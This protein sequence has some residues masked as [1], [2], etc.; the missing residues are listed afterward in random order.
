MV[1]RP[2][3]GETPAEQLA[4]YLRFTDDRRNAHK[5]TKASD[6]ALRRLAKHLVPR[7]SRSR[8]RFLV[9]DLVR[10][11]ARA[12][13]R[14]IAAGH[15]AS[16]KDLLL[17][18]GSGGEHK[19]GWVNIDLA[20]DPVEVPWNLKHPLPFP[21]GSADAVFSE[22]LL[23]HIP[24]FG[25]VDVLRECH[26]VLKPGGIMRVGV[27]DAG[28]MLESYVEEGKGFIETTRPDRPQLMLAVQEL[29]YWYEHVTMYDEEMLTWL[30]TATGFTSEIHRCAPGRSAL[31]VEAPDTPRRRPET[32]YVETVK[33]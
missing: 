31:S 26:R 13:A 15:A 32:L 24:L 17:H 25:V 1:N 22:H 2:E 30:L 3:P 14:R 9:T 18:I 33:P 12:K 6:S 29:F 16:G 4:N 27:P 19:D 23:E 11:A 21:D 5:K 7:N 28:R 10:P 20:G 8:A